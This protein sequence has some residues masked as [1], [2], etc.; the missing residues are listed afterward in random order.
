MERERLDKWLWHARFFRTRA[1][2]QAVCAGGKVRV[3]AVRTVKP[4]QPVAPGDVLTFAQG[5][6]IRVVRVLALA[7][8]RGAA[9]DAQALYEEQPPTPSE[10]PTGRREAAQER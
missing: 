5:E 3:N 10:A 7:E 9:T 4:H 6:R 1:L 8:R 2:A